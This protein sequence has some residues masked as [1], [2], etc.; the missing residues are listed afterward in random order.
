MLGLFRN[1][2][3]TPVDSLID[4]LLAEMHNVGVN[5]ESY[6]ALMANLERLYDIKNKERPDPVSRDTLALIAGNLMGILLIV[7]YEQK[8]VMTSKGFS[9][10]IKP[11]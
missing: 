10:I 8:H 11:K 4:E 1:E 9:Q 6:P 5:A 7:A 2:E 3:P